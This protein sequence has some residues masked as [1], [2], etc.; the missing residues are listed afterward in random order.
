MTFDWLT[1]MCEIVMSNEWRHNMGNRE[2]FY[3]RYDVIPLTTTST[4]EGAEMWNNINGFPQP[5]ILSF[6]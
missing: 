4:F 1:A 3:P 6:F 2:F 5:V